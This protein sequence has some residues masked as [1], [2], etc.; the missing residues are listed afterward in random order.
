[1]LQTA[2]LPQHPTCLLPQSP[3]P[4]P[5][6]GVTSFAG[7][8][9]GSFPPGKMGRVAGCARQMLCML[10]AHAQAYELIKG[11]PGE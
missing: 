10:R 1:M 8:V 7:H 4:T 9:Y 11:M 6:A 3:T 5:P 2:A